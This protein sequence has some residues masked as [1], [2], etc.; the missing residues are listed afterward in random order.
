M[1]TP[2]PTTGYF[3]LL[4]AVILALFDSF[5]QDARDLSMLIWSLLVLGAVITLAPRDP[6]S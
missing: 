3:I 4:V 1:T 2:P 5:V 6:S